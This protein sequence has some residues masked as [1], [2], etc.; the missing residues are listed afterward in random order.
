M[1]EIAEV[2]YVLR[3]DGFPE[4]EVFERLARVYET[5]PPPENADNPLHAYLVE[6]LRTVDPRYLDLGQHVFAVALAMASLRSE[7]H[8]ARV[9]A[10]SW[11][12]PEMLGEAWARKG[13]MAEIDTLLARHRHHAGAEI[14][15]MKA[16]AMPD[17]K[18]H[19]FSTGRDSWRAMMGRGGIA[20]VR[21][22]RS[23]DHFVTMLN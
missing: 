12:R 7:L 3:A 22:G 11:P 15:R 5:P 1:L 6:H 14:R 10:S 8:A 23:I 18:L 9:V 16:R 17:D 2:A 21:N 19:S 20:L 4:P 13:I